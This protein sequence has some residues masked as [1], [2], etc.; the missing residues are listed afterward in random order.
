V[1]PV[2]LETVFHAQHLGSTNDKTSESQNRGVPDE[3]KKLFSQAAQDKD[4]AQALMLALQKVKMQ[5][6]Q[7]QQQRQQ[8]EQELLQQQG[9][10][11]Q[12][13]QGIL[14]Q[15]QQ[16]ILQQQQQGPQQDQRVEGQDPASHDL[17]RRPPE[18]QIREAAQAHPK[19]E[20]QQTEVKMHD[21]KAKNV[22]LAVCSPPNPIQFNPIRSDPICPSIQT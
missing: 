22:R 1:A 8:Q 3:W 17:R 2:A 11:Q 13:Q 14:Q 10:L 15:Q 6:L 9:L 18:D 16:G 21:H 7:Q 4:K 20:I 19:S 5:Q 12:Q